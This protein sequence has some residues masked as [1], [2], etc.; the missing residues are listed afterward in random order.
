MV[1]LVLDASLA[2]PLFDL[3]MR[4]VEVLCDI[5]FVYIVLTDVLFDFAEEL[6]FDTRWAKILFVCQWKRSFAF[7]TKIRKSH[8]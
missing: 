6:L 1:V 4:D 3:H 2:D 8:F 5:I 7:L